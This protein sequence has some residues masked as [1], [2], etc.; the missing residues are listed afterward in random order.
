[1]SPPVDKRHFEIVVVGAGPAGLAAA[2]AASLS[3][4]SIAIIDENPQVG[5]QIWRAEKGQRSPAASKLISRIDGE[6]VEFISGTQVFDA[7]NSTLFC[8]QNGK[9]IEIGYSK[10]IIATGARELFL[11]FPGWTLPGVFGAGGLQ[12]L[13]KGGFDITGKR[14]I[15]AGSGPLLLA[16]ADYLK[17]KGAKVVA[18]NEQ[19]RAGSIRRFAR[20]LWHSPDKLTQAAAL[21]ARLLGIPYKT[22]SFISSVHDEN[23][24][25][26]VIVGKREYRCDLVACGFHL[27]P[28]LEL[29]TLLGCDIENGVVPVDDLQ[30]T[31]IDNIF[32]AGESTGIGG[33][34]KSLIEGEIAGFA[35]VGRNDDARQLLPKRKAAHSFAQRLNHAF[36][37][38][39]ELKTLADHTTLIC[40]CEDMSFGAVKE[41]KSWREAKLQTRCGM[42]PCQGRICGAAARFIFDW[43]LGTA[44]PPIYPVKLENL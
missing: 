17:N 44:R 28:N 27:V 43:E 8:E 2:T 13:V 20:S 10:L 39:D 25:K 23:G 5:G 4:V 18:I 29:P 34:D 42:G 1:M 41:F 40:R 3:N 6:R 32:C 38:R 31:S 36:R 14:V 33:V 24:E 35:A 15:V 26:I 30:R 9:R 21:R 11:P 37:L 22:D 7:A 19:A 16:V 12:A